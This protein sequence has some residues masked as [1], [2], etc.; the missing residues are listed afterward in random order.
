MRK[1]KKNKD[2]VRESLQR[3]D[4]K[5]I[6]RQ[7]VRT[8]KEKKQLKETIRKVK[9]DGWY[10]RVIDPKD[11]CDDILPIY[12]DE[13]YDVIIKEIT[14]S[15]NAELRKAKEEVRKAWVNYQFV[16]KR[17]MEDNPK[18]YY[19]FENEEGEEQTVD[20][21]VW[22]LR[23]TIHKKG[24]T[25]EQADYAISFKNKFILPS[26]RMVNIAKT[27]YKMRLGL[28]TLNSSPAYDN[29]L[30]IIELFGKFYTIEDVKKY[31]KDKLDVKIASNVLK[32]IYR[33]N[34]E[35]IEKRRADYVLRNKDFRIGTDT[36]RLEILND[37]LMDYQLRYQKDPRNES[38]SK[39]ILDILEQARKECK[40]DQIK[41]TVDGQIDINASI[42]GPIQVMQTMRKLNINALVVGL[43]AA[44]AGLNPT[45]LISQL[46]SSWYKD[47]SGFNGNVVGNEKVLSPAA[48]IQQYDWNELRDKSREFTESF[49][50]IEVINECSEEERV[51][52]T[53]NRKKISDLI[54][55]YKSN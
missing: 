20:L 1:T 9:D 12:T 33:E 17:A 15:M 13:E 47:V 34:K 7:E 44:K 53:D 23:E 3:N 36:G 14:G 42:N 18:R 31:M 37:M 2:E 39:R 45:V 21:H 54:N 8:A 4:P 41:L 35:A 11:S 48:L 32:T 52:A 55:R 5:R 24:G 25:K 51:E 19:I 28:G 29:I 27:V 16:Y 30:E 46:A 49:T 43:T 6:A 26:I 38:L 22:R 10:V 40:G 50:P